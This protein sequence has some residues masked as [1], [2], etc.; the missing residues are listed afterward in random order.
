G[1]I[2]SQDRTAAMRDGA[3]TVFVQRGIVMGANIAPREHIFQMFEERRINGHNV[4]E[5]AMDKTVFHHQDLAIAL[6]DLRLD[7]AGFVDVQNIE[8]NLAIENL[9]ADL[10]YAPETKRVRLAGPSQQRLNLFP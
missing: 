6:D 1:Q 2:D 10:R 9:L 4:F 3:G 8:E 5:V 7:F